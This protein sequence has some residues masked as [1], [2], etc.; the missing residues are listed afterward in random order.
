[1]INAADILNYTQ[2]FKDGDEYNSNIYYND[3]ILH[4]TI[5]LRELLIKAA[6]ENS[7]TLNMYCGKFSLF[8]DNTAE[9]IKNLKLEECTTKS[10]TP[11][12]EKEWATFDPFEDLQK[13]LVDFLNTQDGTLNL[14]IERDFETLSKNK[15]W[16]ILKAGMEQNKVRIYKLKEKFGLGHFAVTEE[17]YRIE[18]S[19][20]NKTATGCFKD[21]LNATILNENFGY[22]LNLSDRIAI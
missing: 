20:D 1:M 7:K 21:T 9:K 5:I 8:R 2:T 3:S 14:I 22:L 4:A 12:Q 11:D 13:E 19:D 18:D 15:V 6:Q 16:P 10:L 17:A